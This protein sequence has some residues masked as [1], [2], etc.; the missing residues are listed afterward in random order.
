MWPDIRNAPWDMMSSR[1]PL[2]LLPIKVDF[3][4]GREGHL[5]TSQQ[6]L[7][8]ILGEALVFME[9]QREAGPH[10]RPTG[11]VLLC[12]SLSKEHAVS[13]SLCERDHRSPHL[14]STSPGRFLPVSFPFS[15]GRGL[16]GGLLAL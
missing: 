5:L 4:G 12:G 7:G 8:G 15:M 9:E 13:L 1:N 10:P 2:A 6:T 11:K 16:A 14:S 3:L